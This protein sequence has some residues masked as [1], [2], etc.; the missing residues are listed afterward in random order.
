M[1][2]FLHVATFLVSEA[3]LLLGV[4]RV[5]RGSVPLERVVTECGPNVREYVPRG[6]AETQPILVFV[7]GGGWHA[8][9]I[10]EDVWWWQNVSYA[11]LADVLVSRGAHVAMVGYP[12]CC[13]SPRYRYGF[14]A[15]LASFAVALAWVLARVSPLAFAHWL[16]LG[17]VGWLFVSLLVRS[18][19]MP[20]TQARGTDVTRQYHVVEQAVV[21]LMNQ[22]PRASIVLVGH[23]AGAHLAA[24]V[25]RS[26]R[27]GVAKRITHF[28]GLAGVYRPE[29]LMERFHP[30]LRP[31]VSGFFPREFV[32]G[33]AD[34]L[35][36]L[37]P[38]AL[39]ERDGVLASQRWTIITSQGEPPMLLEQADDF[40]ALI[41][42]ASP[43]SVVR[44]ADVGLGHG[45][46]LVY[47]E[48]AWQHILPSVVP[49]RD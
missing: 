24:L 30:L 28:F 47:A 35:Q 18:R 5:R 27:T 26:P 43:Q 14:Y 25:A 12:L 8:G 3:S 22:Y 44:L 29:R 32:Y 42:N 37:S 20:A 49:V 1:N 4:T 46:G 19:L 17:A 9:T 38:H 6:R 33:S 16:V 15:A 39:V 36:P 45:R 21:D 11:P 7:H 34:E 48:Q 41:R 10:D 2:P 13:T 31:L 40:A 23:S